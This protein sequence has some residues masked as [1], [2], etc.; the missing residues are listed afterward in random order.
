MPEVEFGIEG[1]GPTYVNWYVERLLE[2]GV[3]QEEQ[4]EHWSKMEDVNV[5]IEE[6]K[7]V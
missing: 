5:L 6:R 3:E 7:D 1:I 2:H 4:E